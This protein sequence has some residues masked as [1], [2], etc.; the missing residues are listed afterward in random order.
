[1]SSNVCS[2]FNPEEENFSEFL[3]RFQ[4]QC[5]DQLHKCRNNETQKAHLLIKCLPVSCVTALQRRIA[6]VQLSDADYDLV[7]EN[8]SQQYKTSKSLVGASV[9]FLNYKQKP[10][11]SLED[12]SNNLNKL[13]ADCDYPSA[14]L[15]RLLRDTFVANLAS[16]VILS[17]LIQVCDDLTFRE[18]LERAKLLEAFNRDVKDIHSQH[19]EFYRHKVYQVENIEESDPDHAFQV[20][21][22]K[23]P[24]PQYLCYRCGEKGL[25][26]SD[27]CKAKNFKCN[28]CHKLGHL[29]RICQSNKTKQVKTVLN[30]HQPMR[31]VNSI[32]IQPASSH[33][34]P[35]TSCDSSSRIHSQHNTSDPVSDVT[36]QSSQWRSPSSG[37]TTS[38]NPSCCS[39]YNLG[40][41]A[42]D[43]TRK[44]QYSSTISNNACYSF[45]CDHNSANSDNFLA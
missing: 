18:T 8:L 15:D 12:Y 35:I 21:Q 24:P 34:R 29:A 32:D 28:V 45:P 7:V 16:P 36:A 40:V 13:A 23:T 4:C 17:S 43:V 37:V 26:F 5:S 31:G 19:S 2:P 22:R 30:R 14:C 38:A 41:H 6:P 42:D 44:P 20:T 10:Q 9:T 3:Q 11:Q 1:M 33:S 25:H 27:K 39:S